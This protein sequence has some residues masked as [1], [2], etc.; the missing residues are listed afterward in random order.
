[1]TRPMDLEDDPF[2]W[3]HV[4]VLKSMGWS[5]LAATRFIGTYEASM[6][7]VWKLFI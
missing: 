2:T 5:Q 1:M 6:I 7:E 4:E 3:C